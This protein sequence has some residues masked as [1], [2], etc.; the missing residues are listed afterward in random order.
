[1]VA[2]ALAQLIQQRAGFRQICGVEALGEPAIDG[3]Q[4]LASLIDECG[5]EG[6]GFRLFGGSIVALH[7][8]TAR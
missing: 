6:A 4:Q 7:T 1:M 5:F 2:R 3:G 8:A